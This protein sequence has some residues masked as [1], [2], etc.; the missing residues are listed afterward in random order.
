M[1][2]M[3]LQKKDET[4]LQFFERIQR[5]FEQFLEKKYGT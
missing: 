2:A 3:K 1:E 4:D 5:D